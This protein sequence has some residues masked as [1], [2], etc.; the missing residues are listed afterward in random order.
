MKLLVNYRTLN[1]IECRPIHVRV[2][3]VDTIHFCKVIGKVVNYIAA[4]KVGSSYS[5]FS[6]SVVN[7]I[8]I[9]TFS[10]VVTKYSYK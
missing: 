10:E 1:I 6:V 9:T 4:S 2:P 7:S 8:G 3:I 5:N